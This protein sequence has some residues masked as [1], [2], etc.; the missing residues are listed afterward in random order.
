MTG[1]RVVFSTR[2]AEPDSIEQS[3]LGFHWKTV[4]KVLLVLPGFRLVPP[5]L[6][7]WKGFAEG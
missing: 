1:F 4:L 6:S 7:D 3:S 2:R 5:V